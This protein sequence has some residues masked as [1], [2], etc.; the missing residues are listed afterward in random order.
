MIHLEKVKIEDAEKIIEVR[1]LAY[2]DEDVRFGEEKGT[3]LEFIGEANFVLWCMNRYL[4][5]KMMLDYI[6]IGTFWLD[7]EADDRPNHFE[8]QDFCILPEY[9]NK[10]YGR[11]VIK[12]T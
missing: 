6:I 4:L 7:H 8:L 2:T 9:Q 5:Y 10:G 11:K 3:Y 12:P 1:K